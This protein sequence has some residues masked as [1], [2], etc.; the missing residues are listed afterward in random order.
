MRPTTL[1]TEKTEL[2]SYL[3]TATENGY[4]YSIKDEK[5]IIR[6]DLFTGEVVTYTELDEGTKFPTKVQDSWLISPNAYI[7][8]GNGI[9]CVK[10]TEYDLTASG[11]V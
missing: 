7:S 8:V 10:L 11:R 6:T 2:D 3:F 4:S 5:T 9:V 1:K